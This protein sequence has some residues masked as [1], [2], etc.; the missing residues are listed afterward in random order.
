M[1]EAHTVAAQRD[2]TTL[3]FCTVT[4]NVLK[5]IERTHKYMK[6]LQDDAC[7]SFFAM[8]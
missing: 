3:H 1:I 2:L 7:H 5:I 4:K 8:R 6:Q